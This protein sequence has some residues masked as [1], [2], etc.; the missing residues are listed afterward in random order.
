MKT[1][2]Y[3]S[4][5]STAVRSLIPAGVVVSLIWGKEFAQAYKVDSVMKTRAEVSKEAIQA[6]TEPLT[7]PIQMTIVT[8]DTHISITKIFDNNN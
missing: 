2:H 4:G 6:K 8:T 1:L 3:N 7:C 5:L